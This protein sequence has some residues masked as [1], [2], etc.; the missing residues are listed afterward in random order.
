MFF[1]APTAVNILAFKVNS[2]DNGSVVGAGPLQ[3]IDQFVSYKR[4][5]ALGEINGDLSPSNVPINLLAD[6]DLNDSSSVKN[7]AV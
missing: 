7:S 1:F 4:N 3:Y 2:N 5:Q 6:P